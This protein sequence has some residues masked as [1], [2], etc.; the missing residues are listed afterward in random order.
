MIEALL[1]AVAALATAVSILFGIIRADLRD[2]KKRL[3]EC[4]KDRLNLWAKIAQKINQKIAD[5][6]QK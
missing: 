5:E 2:V 3:E 4:E 6:M 1:A